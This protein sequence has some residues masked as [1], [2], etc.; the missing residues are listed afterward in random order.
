MT[1][2]HAAALAAIHADAF[3]PGE[4]W[5]EAAFAELLAMPGSYGWLDARGGLALAR[6]AG[7]EAE[8]LTLAVVPQARRQ[9]LGRGLVA[10]VL[11]EA[12]GPMFLEVAADNAAALALYAALRFLPCGRRRDYYGAGRDAVVL[13]CG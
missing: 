10:A 8:L 12:C 3:P 2:L 5:N 11:A 7:G 6:H 9:G 1:A 13:R 4:R